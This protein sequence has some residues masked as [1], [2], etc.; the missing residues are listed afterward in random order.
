MLILISK[1][2]LTNSQFPRSQQLVIKLLKEKVTSYVF[3]K[4]QKEMVL[5]EYF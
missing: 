5:N 1:V 4:V 2:R 3:F